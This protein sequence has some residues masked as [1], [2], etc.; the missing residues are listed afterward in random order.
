MLGSGQIITSDR[1]WCNYSDLVFREQLD[2][3]H[4]FQQVRLPDLKSVLQ[5]KEPSSLFSVLDP[6]ECEDLAGMLMQ[7]RGWRML[8]SS[9]YRSQRDTECIFRQSDALAPNTAYLQVKSGNSTTLDPNDFAHL[10]DGGAKVYLFSTA[11]RPY[12]ERHIRG[13]VTLDPREVAGFLVDNLHLLAPA[14]LVR[15]AIWARVLGTCRNDGA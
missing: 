14:T 1:S 6:D 11:A 5:A 13:V 12:V 10:A 4:L 7:D 15:L 9:T 2:S 8:K 3:H